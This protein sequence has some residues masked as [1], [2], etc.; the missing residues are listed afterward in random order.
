M[1]GM[2]IREHFPT[3]VGPRGT[4]RREMSFPARPT[5]MELGASLVLRAVMSRGWAG[6]G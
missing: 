4:G 3:A 5:K 1:G 6:S 2:C